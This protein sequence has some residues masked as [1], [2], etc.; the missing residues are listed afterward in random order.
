MVHIER[1]PLTQ[2]KKVAVY[3]NSKKKSLSQIVA[4]QQPD[5]AMTAAFYDPGDWRPVCPVKADGRI[6]HTDPEYNYWAIA[7]NSG[8]DVAEVLIPPGGACTQDN[9]VANCLLI[10]EGTP[11]AKLYYNSDVA[12]RRG[13]VAVGLTDNM[14]ITYG[15]TDGSSGAYTPEQLRDYMAKQGCRFAIMMDGGGKVNVYVKSAGVMMEGRDPSNTLI[16]L[17]LNDKEDKEEN[18][19]SEKKSVVLDAGHDASNLANKSPDGT[20]YEHE[21]ALD[22]AQ[23][24]RDHLVRCGVEVTETRPN[25]SAVS[26]A[27]RCKI[28]NSITGLDLFISLHSNAAGG[29]EWSSAKGWS[30]Y[31]Y[32]SGGEREKAANAI[33]EEVR[34]AGVTVRSVPIVYD[35]ELYVLKNTCA[36]A[37]LIEHGFHTNQEDTANLKDA[38]WRTRVAEAEAKGIVNYLGLKWIEEDLQPPAIEPSEPTEAELAEAWA[39]SK[40]VMSGYADGEMHLDDP[41]TRRQLMLVAYRLAKLGGFAE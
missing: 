26:L 17:W 23:R 25:G 41:V 1:T 36:P 19:V 6:L 28:A 11:Q 12:G 13:R 27:N 14:W 31:L 35:P 5:I 37:V 39:K 8:P 32:E 3:V 40:G 34:A 2:V 15:A 18:P 16:L 9:Y 29:S 22:M 20:Y 30:C 33:L 24:I 7:W 38:A 21:F 10:R 4:E